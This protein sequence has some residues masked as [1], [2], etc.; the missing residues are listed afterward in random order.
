MLFLV[1]SITGSAQIYILGN[2]LLKRQPLKN[3]L[4]VVK[5]GDK[6]VSEFNTGNKNEF[7]VELEYGPV[8]KII[9]SHPDCATM[10]AQVKSDDVPKEKYEYRMKYAFDANFTSKS[11]TLKDTLAYRVPFH[12]IKF[13]GKNRMID[14]ATWNSAFVLA[15]ERKGTI[16]EDE[17]TLKLKKEA[18]EKLAAQ[19]VVITPATNQVKEETKVLSGRIL[20]HGNKKLPVANRALVLLDANGNNVQS[21][22]TNRFGSF[23]FTGI[24][25]D[26]TYKILMDSKE[27][28]TQLYTILDESGKEIARCE[29]RVGQCE[30]LFDGK[31]TAT[32]STNEFSS[33]IG[34]KM[35]ITSGTEKMLYADKK[36]FLTDLSN[37]VLSET[38]TNILGTFVFEGIQPGK[39]YIIGVDHKELKSGEKI[40]ILSKEDVY[41][42]TLDTL[43]NGMPCMKLSTSSTYKF[44]GMAI[45]K[46]E[47]RMQLSA[48]VYGNDV[49][50]PISNLKILLL[51]DNNEIFD[52]TFTDQNG[53]FTFKHLPYLK[54][55]YISADNNQKQLD[56]YTNILLYSKGKNLV[57][58]MPYVRGKKFQYKMLEADIVPL[59]EMA[60]EDPWLDFLDPA[61]QRKPNNTSITENILFESNSAN[62]N[63]QA[64]T[65]LDK[66]ILVLKA[67][68]KLKI[69]IGAHTDS[70][71]N[72]AANLKLS[73]QRA[74]SVSAYMVAAG[75]DQKRITATGY[76]ESKLLNNCTDD[77]G[78]SEIE[79]A[80]NR[81][82]EFKIIG[83]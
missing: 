16:P 63:Q 11:D 75:I 23:I 26:E 24:K 64:R 76:G 45:D 68:N 2:T 34:G 42:T 80:V 67:N 12:K 51:N 60:L 79:H 50:H 70:R 54:S 46:D 39:D 33:T 35:V 9:L 4:V 27:N 57:K 36:V 17:Y 48:S 61:Y 71:G 53:F 22:M 82:I 13:D 31:N 69:Q 43:V 52:S 14:E 44:A 78:C 29:N 58:M 3:V 37:K 5:K 25:S 30:F 56:A 62:L 65:V 73:Q 1:I 47:I 15:L 77:A 18:E 83:N 6:T 74:A 32:Y 40:D 19:K 81:R 21:G 38:K 59:K 10:Y 41:I 49:S 66:V 8:Y 7:L 20:V 55:F 72:D 28:Q